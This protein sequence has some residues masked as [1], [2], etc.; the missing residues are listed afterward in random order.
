MMECGTIADEGVGG[1]DLGYFPHQDICLNAWEVNGTN[2][3]H[4]VLL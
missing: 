4:P 3:C 2:I 1:R